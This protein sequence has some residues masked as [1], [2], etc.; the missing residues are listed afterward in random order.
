MSQFDDLYSS[1]FSAL[2]DFM[3]TWVNVYDDL[4]STGYTP[5]LAIF[6]SETRERD[7]DRRDEDVETGTLTVKLADMPT[8]EVGTKIE[9]NGDIWSIQKHQGV[10]GAVVL[11]NIQKSER[12]T[13]GTVRSGGK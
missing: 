12:R 10:S 7:W 13:I 11:L 8:I 4:D 1:S 3:G 9:I 2:N 6:L 5:V